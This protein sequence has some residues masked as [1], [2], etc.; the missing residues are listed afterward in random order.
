MEFSSS[1]ASG[2][3]QAWREA[4]KPCT[5]GRSQAIPEQVSPDVFY[6]SK[7]LNLCRRFA[8]QIALFLVSGE[9]KGC[10]QG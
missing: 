4:P 2:L 7:V 8:R 3:E 5:Q 1:L 6:L 10:G 9:G